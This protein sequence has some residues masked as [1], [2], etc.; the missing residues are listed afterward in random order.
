[1][2]YTGYVKY[3]GQF[4][5]I[6][7][8]VGQ[9]LFQTNYREVVDYDAAEWEYV[10]FHDIMLSNKE[11]VIIE[12]QSED[13]LFSPIKSRSAT[14]KI[15]TKEI[16]KPFTTIKKHDELPV[17]IT[18]DGTIIFEGYVTPFVY[19]QKYSQEYETLSIECVDRLSALEYYQ[20]TKKQGIFTKQIVNVGD[21]LRTILNKLNYSG[22]YY[23]PIGSIFT[24]QSLFSDQWVI[25]KDFRSFDI[26]ESIYV[27]ESNFF[28][29]DEEATPWTYKEIVEEICRLLGWSLVPYRNNLYFID[30]TLIDS[31]Y[32]EGMFQTTNFNEI[33]FVAQPNFGGGEETGSENLKDWALPDKNLFP[34]INPNLQPSDPG[35]PKKSPEQYYYTQPDV[36]KN[37]LGG[38]CL[39]QPTSSGSSSNKLSAFTENVTPPKRNSSPSF[40]NNAQ[41]NQVFYDLKNKEI[42][43]FDNDYLKVKTEKITADMYRGK[44]HSI[45]YDDTYNKVNVSSNLFEVDKIIGNPWTDDWSKYIPIIVTKKKDGLSGRNYYDVQKMTVGTAGQNFWDYY[46][47]KENWYVYGQF[48]RLVPGSGWSTRYWYISPTQGS[49]AEVNTPW[50]GGRAQLMTDFEGWPISWANGNYYDYDNN[51]WGV[52]ERTLGNTIGAHIARFWTFEPNKKS[53]VENEATKCIV[54]HMLSWANQKQFDSQT[55]FY[56]FGNTFSGFP[57]NYNLYYA[58][59]KV[60]SNGAHDILRYM[61]SLTNLPVLTYTCPEE[62][63]YL[64][65]RDQ[66]QDGFGAIIIKG[67]MLWQN[68]CKYT[69]GKTTINCNIWSDRNATTKSYVWYP[70]NLPSTS[71]VQQTNV[72]TRKAG[73]AG[74]GL[75]WPMLRC[76]L[77]IGEK[78]DN[79][80]KAIGKWW[81]G[82]TWQSTQATFWICFHK[83][84]VA[85]AKGEDEVFAYGGWMKMVPNDFIKG[86][87]NVDDIWQVIGEDGYC[88]PLPTVS[89]RIWFTMYAPRQWVP[90]S[91]WFYDT[92]TGQFTYDAPNKTKCK[93]ENFTPCV[94]MKDF[95]LEYKYIPAG[96]NWMTI[97]DY[98]DDED[99]IYSIDLSNGDP[100][101]EFNDIELKIN[102]YAKNKPLSRSYVLDKKGKHIKS[103]CRNL[104]NYDK[105]ESEQ[106]DSY[107]NKLINYSILKKPEEYL[108]NMYGRHYLTSKQIYNACM[109]QY[110]LPYKPY[111]FQGVPGVGDPDE[112]KRFYIDTQSWDVKEQTNQVKFIQI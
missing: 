94:F 36:N 26:L 105:I 107:G 81:N 108:L 42:V 6:N 78:D 24:D 90:S 77:F 83:E 51:S 88:I 93:L 95:S 82:Q 22:R 55:E 5:D 28:D 7:G 37:D 34:P 52:V 1:M 65:G 92:T 27:Y 98:N 8:K 15:V 54:F 68:N 69:Q 99:L 4:T 35:L 53:K 47:G 70:I 80:N 25:K 41:Y 48:F 62:L 14:I 91:Q 79:T 76:E 106:K 60:I 31:Y 75:G 67:S 87:E 38:S 30:Y 44:N 56:M 58:K 109:K 49:I 73:T 86:G 19:S 13:G 12:T 96:F 89:G 59:E 112:N 2:A 21:L 110:L 17:T 66:K 97:E 33:R 102:T 74:Y 61:D 64:P 39:T 111:M 29:D 72:W 104:A 50:D 43:V 20:Y 23:C 84:E 40:N 63:Q 11:P 103:W 32:K 10:E 85:F 46:S 45:S 16:I 100:V 71:Y 3:V 18:L 57:Y 101:N 9:V